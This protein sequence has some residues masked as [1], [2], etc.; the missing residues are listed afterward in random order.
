MRFII[1]LVAAIL[2]APGCTKDPDLVVVVIRTTNSVP[3][4]T[5]CISWHHN[6]STELRVVPEITA[7]SEISLSYQSGG[8]G[9]GVVVRLCSRPTDPPIFSEYLSPGLHRVSL[10]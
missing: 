1:A 9:V 2:V 4:S 8:E 5:L 7:G 6:G 10:Q 3:A